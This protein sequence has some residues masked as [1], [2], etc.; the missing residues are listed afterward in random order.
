MLNHVGAV[1]PGGR[2]AVARLLACSMLTAAALLASGA[3]AQ[4]AA[5]VPVRESIDGNGVDLFLGTMNADGPVL[6]AGQTDAGLSWNKLARGNQAWGDNLVATLSVSGSTVVV[7]YAGRTDR[8]TISGSSYAPTEGNGSTL[9]LSGNIYTYVLAD[10]TVIHFNKAYVGAAM[11]QSITGVVTDVTKPSGEKLTYTFESMYYCSQSKEGA[12]GQICTGH[13]YAYRV[14]SVQ[15]TSGYKLTYDN[16]AQFADPTDIFSTDWVAWNTTYGVSLTNTA[17]S[18]ATSRYMATSFSGTVGYSNLT[19]TDPI[20]R[21]TVYRRDASGLVGIKRPGSSTE[22]VQITYSGG[23]V[24]AIT[25]PAGPTSYSSYDSAGVRYVTVTPP[26]A[27]ATN[28]TFNIASQRMTSMTDPLSRTTSWQYDSSGRVTRVTRPEG[29]YTQITYDTRGNVTE[30]R[31]VA[32]SGSGLADIVTPANYDLACGSAA[33]CNQPNWTRDAKGN[34]TD[35]TYNTSTGDLLTIVGPAASSG[36]TRPTTT[37]SYTTVNGVQRLGGVSACQTSASCAGTADEVKTSISYDANGLPNLIS[38]GAGNSSLTTTTSIAY[39]D[40]GNVRT[41]DGLL[42]GTADTTRYRYDAARQLVGVVSPDPDGGSALKPRAQRITYDPKGRATLT[43]TGNVDSQSD[44][45]WAGFSSQQQLATDYDGV[46]RLVKQTLS[47]GGVTYRV[48]QRSY[49]VSGTYD[50]TAVRMNSASWSSLPDACTATTGGSAGPDR[51]TRNLYDSARQ[52]TTVQSA[53][54]TADQAN[55]ASTYTNNGRLASVTD[56]EGNKTSYEYDGFDRL[57]KTWYPVATVGAATSSGSDYEQLSYDAASNLTLRRLRDGQTIGFSY[58]NLNRITIKDLPGSEPDVSYSYNLLGQVTGA[59]RP[60]IAHSFSYDALGRLTSETQPFGSI[61]YQYDLAGRR[62]R[63]SWWDGIYIDYDYLTTGEVAKIRENGA[64]SGVGVLAS[65]SY[66]QLGRRSGIARGNGTGT[67]YTYDSISRLASLS[68]DLAGSTY[69]FTHGYSYN[70]A[71]QIASLTRSNDTYAW[72]GHYNVDR[73]YAING[74]NQVTSAGLTGI[75]YDARGNLNSSGTAV[76]TYSAENLLKSAPGV[77]LYY[78]ALGR[79]V[80]YDTSTSTRFVYDGGNIVAEVSNPSGGVLRRYVFGPGA[81][82]ALVWYEGSGTSDRRWL[83]TDERGSVVAV[84][85][86][87]GNG[88]GVNSYDEYGIPGAANIGRFQ[89]TG[90]AWLP[91][92]GMFYYKARIYS[93]TLG[94]FMQTDPIGYSDSLNWYNYVGNDPINFT[95][96]TGLCGEDEAHPCPPIV[97][98]G[99][100]KRSP[101]VPVQV[102]GTP[103]SSGGNGGGR[104]VPYKKYRD[105]HFKL[106]F[107]TAC[108]ADETFDN[109]KGSGAAPGAPPS[110]D[111]TSPGVPLFGLFAPNPITQYVN[112]RTRE[113]LNVTEPPHMFYLGQVYLHVVPTGNN[114]SELYIEG[115]GNGGLALVNDTLGAAIFTEIGTRVTA[116]CLADAGLPTSFPMP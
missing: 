51:I 88:I 27:G 71:G 8:F 38:K 1:R 54:G 66:D 89:Y 4:V 77:T 108:S 5:V 74:L 95:D 39:D 21:A 17:V 113:I 32:K 75:G 109:L 72:N 110:K 58:D 83:H 44:V 101:A 96:P 73:G 81:D 62:T 42:A 115:T 63:M 15:S 48:T 79:L 98:T 102:V 103:P 67:S 70:P 107:F 105:L 56:G 86:V 12:D 92:L 90:Q 59:T 91:E 20:G 55:E 49:D 34:Q 65:Y 82:E 104:G 36:G 19:I 114:T 116:A 87:S 22:D 28:Y 23:R 47:S 41:I 94:R 60:D 40:A 112:S 84:S 7:G 61:S 106:R 111:G 68:Q 69:D 31:E 52:V 2:R 100:K 16:A 93:P 80:E 50:C 64:T 10:G 9:S 26:D 78:D 43:E 30:R 29:N 53:Y 14:S 99:R 85:D 46:D 76:F 18:G 97:V 37:Y 13:S 3:R 35:Y 57:S 11:F 24:S 6:S 45:D 25:T 33:K